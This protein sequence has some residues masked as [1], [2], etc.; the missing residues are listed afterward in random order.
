MKNVCVHIVFFF[1]CI[2]TEHYGSDH[3]LISINTF[4]VLE[5]KTNIVVYESKSHKKL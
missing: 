2:H 5:E 1:K 3:Y 4:C